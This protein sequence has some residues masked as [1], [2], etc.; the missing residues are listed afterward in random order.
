MARRV[1]VPTLGLSV[2][3]LLAEG[4][5]RGIGLRAVGLVRFAA[6]FSPRRA[7]LLAAE[8]AAL[9]SPQTDPRYARTSLE[10]VATHRTKLELFVSK[11]PA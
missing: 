6:P 7:S 4:A 8:A 1:A 10:G 11:N 3:D 2:L 5:A 9:A